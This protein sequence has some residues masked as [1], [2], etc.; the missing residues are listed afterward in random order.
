MQTP[1]FLMNLPQLIKE[2]SRCLHKSWAE[3]K[4]KGGKNNDWN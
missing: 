1:E 2:E 4:I 3:S